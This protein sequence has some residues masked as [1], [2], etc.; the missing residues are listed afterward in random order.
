MEGTAQLARVCKVLLISLKVWFDK[1]GMMKDDDPSSALVKAQA[2][3]IEHTYTIE[4]FR[5][6]LYMI[7]LNF[8]YQEIK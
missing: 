8:L 1:R 6:K 3:T 7:F 2:T 4:H 5:I